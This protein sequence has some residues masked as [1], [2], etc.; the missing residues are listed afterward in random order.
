AIDVLSC[1]TVHAVDML[2]WMGGEPAAVAADV[3]RRCNTFDDS[4][5]ALVRFEGGATGILLGNWCVGARAHTFEM[6][7]RWISAYVNPDDRA[8]IFADGKGQPEVITTQEAAGSTD[9]RVYYGFAAEN[10]HFVDCI[11]EGKPP[12]S[13]L[14]DAA[15]TMRLVNRIYA[16]PIDGSGARWAG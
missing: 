7:G 13:S 9:S 3:D 14:A 11:R 10:R 4:F 2:R 1:D 5:N 6:H 12:S 15:L 8:V 16:S